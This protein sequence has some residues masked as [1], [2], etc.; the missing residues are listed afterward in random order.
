MESCAFAPSGTRLLAGGRSGH[1]A[2]FEVSK[3][4]RLKEIGQFA[5]H[6]NDVKC[7]AVSGDSRF[8]LSG[9]MEKKARLWEIESGREAAVF[10]E[11]EGPVKACQ[12][13]RDGRT[14]MCTDGA[15]LL[16]LNLSGKPVVTRRRKLARTW[17]SGQAAAISNDGK[18]VAVGDGY[19]V[20]MWNL[21]EDKEL[22]KMDAGEIQW[23][24]TF[25]PDS[26]RLLTGGRSKMNIWDVR[27]QR[28]IHAQEI[29]ESGY[30]QSLAASPD[31]KH[32]A[33]A[34]S[35]SVFVFRLPA[36]R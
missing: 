36:V 19:A 8:A 9:S 12:L 18:I 4:S 3:D 1:I 17:A 35:R 23:S 16:E 24:M 22:A 30:I 28:R 34:G 31:N 7:I 15:T 14:G 26:S 13:S 20:R 33:A 6:S 32:A 21:E 25:T 11:F 29:P 5:G 2:I 10:A 27:G